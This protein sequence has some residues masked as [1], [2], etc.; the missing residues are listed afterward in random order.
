MT[1]HISS[2]P[3]DETHYVTFS[4]GALYKHRLILNIVFI[5]TCLFMNK[6]HRYL[7]YFSRPSKF[8]THILLM[9][10]YKK[11][12][13]CRCSI[14]WDL[15]FGGWVGGEDM[16]PPLPLAM[17]LILKLDLYNYGFIIQFF[18]TV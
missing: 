3:C 18:Y 15:F 6:H 16:S 13:T 11:Y 14:V 12:H 4:G 9:N 10:I 7:N 17:C 1:D 5:P 2:Q 8:V